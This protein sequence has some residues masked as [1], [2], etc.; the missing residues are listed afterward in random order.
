MYPPVFA[1]C[2]ADGGVTATFGSSPCRVY[3]FGEAPQNVTKPYCVWQVISGLPENYLAGT[4]DMD[5]YSIQFDVYSDTATG[6]REGAEAIRDA[7][8]TDC[9][10]TGWQGESRDPDTNNYRF[11][12]GADWFV[13]RVTS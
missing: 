7:I 5:S 6:S 13:T 12:F 8:E 9:H 4:P 11:T 1:T 2:S 10:I 3:P